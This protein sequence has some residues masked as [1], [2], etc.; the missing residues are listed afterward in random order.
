MHAPFWREI[1]KSLASRGP[2]RAASGRGES[3]TLF[4][5][6]CEIWASLTFPVSQPTFL[7]PTLGPANFRP[8]FPLPSRAS[9]PSAARRAKHELR[10]RD[11]RMRSKCK[12]E[13]KES[14]RK[15]ARET[16]A[17][18]WNEGTF[19]LCSMD[20]SLAKEK[21][22]R[23]EGSSFRDRA[24]YKREWEE[25]RSFPLPLLSFFSVF[26]M[27]RSQKSVCDLPPP[28]RSRTSHHH[29]LHSCVSVTLIN[30]AEKCINSFDTGDLHL[31]M[32]ILIFPPH[33]ASSRWSIDELFFVT[34]ST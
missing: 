20:I 7:T 27:I 22:Q 12:S 24:V 33:L 4:Q 14:E 32:M 30:A 17:E 10:L 26:C 28:P 1:L 15:R 25:V 31:H 23:R 18:G 11:P 16:H 29:M 3:C 13:K 21:R 8:I 9:N 2:L 5:R 19:L 34:R 6:A